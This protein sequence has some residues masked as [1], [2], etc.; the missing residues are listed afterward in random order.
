MMMMSEKA[1]ETCIFTVKLKATGIE[2]FQGLVLALR[3]EYHQLPNKV[4]EAFDLL[5]SEEA[6]EDE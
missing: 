6:D 2:S 1:K 4:K 3:D 5:E